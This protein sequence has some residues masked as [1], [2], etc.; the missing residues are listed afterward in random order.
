MNKET[1]KTNIEASR[2]IEKA[3]PYFK[4][5][6][7]QRKHN[8]TTQLKIRRNLI[9]LATR[10]GISKMVYEYYALK[11]QRVDGVF[12]KSEFRAYF[13][14]AYIL[15]NG[16]APSKQTYYNRKHELQEC[17]LLI[18]RKQCYTLVSYLNFEKNIQSIIH[19]KLGSDVD[20]KINQLTKSWIKIDSTDTF[21]QEYQSIIAAEHIKSKN[22]LKKAKQKDTLLDKLKS[23]AHNNLPIKDGVRLLAEKIRHLDSERSVSQKTVASLFGKKSRHTGKSIV[24]N[25]TFLNYAAGPQQIEVIQAN[26]VFT[27][28]I[29]MSMKDE[30]IWYQVKDAFTKVY[31]DHYKVSSFSLPITYNPDTLCFYIYH[32]KDLIINGK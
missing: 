30:S 10:A 18:D 4:S 9:V 21:I 19:K 7:Y 27:P 6:A 23:V 20:G 25:N 17:G 5:V 28:G 13:E 12:K 31:K 11:M 14:D 16:K 15:L 3:L 26:E 8:P 29:I 32:P 22:L 2:L 1:N 24:K